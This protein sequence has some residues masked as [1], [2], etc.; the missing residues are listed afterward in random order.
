MC[1]Q[2]GAGRGQGIVVCFIISFFTNAGKGMFNWIV[3]FILSVYLLA[4]KE[5]IKTGSTRFLKAIMPEKKYE[6]LNSFLIHCDAVLNRYIVF[7]IIDAL[8]VGT[9]NARNT[10]GV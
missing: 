1:V 9:V 6:S 5:R 10:R 2:C 4:G 7:T 8:I 3:S